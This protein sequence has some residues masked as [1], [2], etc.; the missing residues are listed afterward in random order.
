VVRSLR[1]GSDELLTFFR[2]P[3]AQWKRGFRE[4]SNRSHYLTKASCMVTTI[5]T[6]EGDLSI[7]LESQNSPPV[8]FLLIHPALT[9]EGA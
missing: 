8:I 4:G 3:K 2:F 6:E 5:P 1:E 7:G 9:M